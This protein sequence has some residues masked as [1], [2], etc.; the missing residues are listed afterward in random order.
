MLHP[1][2]TVFDPKGLPGPE[3]PPNRLPLRALLVE[4]NPDDVAI[5]LRLLRRAGYEPTWRQVQTAADLAAALAESAWDI[6]L[7]DYTMPQFDALSA[8][9]VVR[10]ES[11]LPAVHHYLGL[12]RGGNRRCRDAG[13]SER[14]PD[15]DQPR[16]PG[17]GD[18]ARAARIGRPARALAHEESAAGFAGQIPG[19]FS[20]IPGCHDD[21]RRVQRRRPARQPRRLLPIL[22][23][24]ANR[25]GGPVVFEVL[26]PEQKPSYRLRQILERVR[27]EG[28][29]FHSGNR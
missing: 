7:S 13:G 11:A 4:D 23:Y 12:H 21:P 29:V 19:H 3:A 8:L 18:R 9:R 22:G 10:D 1:A 16:A 26:W 28:S 15:E 6:V 14:L 2:V 24:D 27:R 17:T 25:L 5:V 20:R